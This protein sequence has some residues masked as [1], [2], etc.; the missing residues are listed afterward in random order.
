MLSIT[1]TVTPTFAGTPATTVSSTPWRLSGFKREGPMPA[2]IVAAH[3]SGPPRLVTDLAGQSIGAGD[4]VVSDAELPGERVT[5][6]V[7]GFVWW[8]PEDGPS[9][10]PT[11]RIHPHSDEDQRADGTENSLVRSGGIT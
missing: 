9:L 8:K 5:R 6:P 10:F 7:A 3:P 1:L 2:Y 11:L 4:E